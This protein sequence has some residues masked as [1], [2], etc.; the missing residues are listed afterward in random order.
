[1]SLEITLAVA[2][3]AVGLVI[4][5]RVSRSR[6]TAGDPG[7]RAISHQGAP[8]TVALQVSGADAAGP[9]AG[10]ELA[11]GSRGTS[12]LEASPLEASPL[13]ASPL[14]ASPLGASPPDTELVAA[15]AG[16]AGDQLCGGPGR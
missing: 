8:M 11:A 13:E 12:P 16:G 1:M 5:R 7:V 9:L 4:D 6:R 2:L 3:F 15:R 10:R 14:E